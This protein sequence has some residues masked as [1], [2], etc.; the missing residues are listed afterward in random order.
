MPWARPATSP[1]GAPKPLERDS[2]VRPRRC[3]INRR[4][5]RSLGSTGCGKLAIGLLAGTRSHTLAIVLKGLTT[6]LQ[7]IMLLRLVDSGSAI[8]D[9]AL[10]P[11]ESTKA[12]S[13]YRGGFPLRRWI[14]SVTGVSVQRRFL[15]NFNIRRLSMNTAKIAIRLALVSVDPRLAVLLD[16]GLN[17]LLSIDT[18]RCRLEEHL[19]GN[20]PFL[21][22]P[23]LA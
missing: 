4:E 7:T 19:S 12:A 14:Q 18:P 11:C 10:S 22:L 16:E 20:N 2:N 9:R 5:R 23:R 13:V 3:R 17:S 1:R 6:A 8:F 21:N 15:E